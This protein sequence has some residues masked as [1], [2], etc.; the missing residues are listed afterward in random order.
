MAPNA[1]GEEGSHAYQHRDTCGNRGRK[2][3]RHNSN[4]DICK[5]AADHE[6]LVSCLYSTEFYGWAAKIEILGTS[7]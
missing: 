7:I 4:A 5:K 6:L 3:R 1:A 2:N